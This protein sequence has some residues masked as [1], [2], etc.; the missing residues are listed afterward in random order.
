MDGSGGVL[1]ARIT[2]D[3]AIWET[4]AADLTEDR[5]ELF[6]C[7]QASGPVTSVNLVITHGG[8][9]PL[10]NPVFL[11]DVYNTLLDNDAVKT[12]LVSR[13]RLPGSPGGNNQE[14]ACVDLSDELVA[15]D[16]QPSYEDGYI[17]D[18]ST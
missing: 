7:I 13:D 12:D 11:F 9:A 2:V 3:G 18:R 17:C 1:G 5:D 8:A 14:T 4:P 15:T 10:V 6:P 16:W